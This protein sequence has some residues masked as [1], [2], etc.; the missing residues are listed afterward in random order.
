MRVAVRGAFVTGVN[1][2]PTS[3]FHVGRRG[4]IRRGRGA[5]AARV[6]GV[7][8]VIRVGRYRLVTSWQVS[9]QPAVTS[10]LLRL[11]VV[12]DVRAAERQI[13]VGP[14]AGGRDCQ[15]IA[16]HAHGELSVVV[17]PWKG[18]ALMIDADPVGLVDLG[19]APVRSKIVHCFR[20]GG[21]RRSTDNHLLPIVDRLLRVVQC[22]LAV[23]SLKPALTIRALSLIVDALLL[24]LGRGDVRQAAATGQFASSAGPER[25]Y[26]ALA[27]AARLGC[28]GK[29]AELLRPGRG[30]QCH[31]HEGGS[32]NQTEH[33]ADWNR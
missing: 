5:L 16:V 6:A 12:A 23:L 33:A 24:A 4:G 30:G 13:H 21:G 8:V 28:L 9:I 14:C 15:V 17:S 10:C 19:R 3:D 29:L 27:V 22:K 25:V 1:T 32:H 2:M 26:A 20:F 7:L 11:G 31:S 18:G